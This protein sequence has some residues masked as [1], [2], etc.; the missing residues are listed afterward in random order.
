MAFHPDPSLT[1]PPKGRIKDESKGEMVRSE[2]LVELSILNANFA[3]SKFS[4]Q[5]EPFELVLLVTVRQTV[6]RREAV[7]PSSHPR[8]G[9][10]G[11]QYPPSREETAGGTGDSARPRGATEEGQRVFN[12][13]C[14]LLRLP[15]QIRTFVVL[16]ST[17]FLEARYASKNPGLVLRTLAWF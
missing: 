10:L 5:F 17:W 12:K 9:H 15:L 16:C 11:R 8:Q 7:W 4:V 6:L 13:T 3:N 2:A 14:L 1:Q